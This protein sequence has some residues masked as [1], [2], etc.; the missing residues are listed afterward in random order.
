MAVTF[1]DY[2]GD[3]VEAAHSVLLELVRLLGEYR[4]DLVVVGGWRSEERR[5]GKECVP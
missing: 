5:V 3:L 1:R 4:D 2:S